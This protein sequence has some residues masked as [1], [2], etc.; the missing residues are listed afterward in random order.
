M[1]SVDTGSAA[2]LPDGAVSEKTSYD[3]FLSYSHK[4]RDEFGIEYI[5]R[6]KAEIEKALEPIITDHK[7]RVFLDA[8]ALHLGDHWH[9]KIMESLNQCKAV[10]CLVSEAYLKSEYCTRERLWW[11]AK[12]TRAGRFLDGPYPVY[13]VKLEQGLFSDRRD[14]KELMAV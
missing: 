2:P 7:P 14:V 3:V 13:F 12:Q 4:D 9:S 5:E 8:E 1:S 10:V 6:I 11:N